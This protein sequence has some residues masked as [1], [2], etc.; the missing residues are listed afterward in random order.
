[1]RVAI[2]GAGPSGL[3]CAL[4]LQRLGHKP[5][6]F[7]RYHRVGHPVERVDTLLHLAWLPVRDQLSYLARK[8]GLHLHPLAPL[9]CIIMSSPG[10]RVTVR[11][12]RLGYLLVRGRSPLSIENQ[13]A[14]GLKSPVIFETVA[15]PQELARDFDWVVV[16][17]GDSKPTRQLNLWKEYSSAVIK[18][19]LV[20]GEFDPRTFHIFWDTRYAGHSFGYLAPLDRNRASIHLCIGGIEPEEIDDYWE[21]FLESEKLHYHIIETYEQEFH[22]GQPTRHRTGNI[23]LVGNSGGFVCSLL[24]MGLFPGLISGVLAARAIAG[25]GDYEKMVQPLTRR[26]EQLNELRFHLE[27]LD[28]RSLDRL[29]GILG[30]PVIKHL[31]Y[32]SGLNIIPII[33]NML[34]RL[35][36]STLRTRTAK[37]RH[38]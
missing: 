5:I 27:K 20:L 23:L 19:A 1:M 31:I 6:I 12:P 24:G 9:H 17:T 29:V 21:L 10:H 32:H 35:T 22:C 14:A 36:G 2:I 37:A 11:S 38:R 13:L 28:N 3:A 25:S 15:D 18:G 8:C 33:C 4:E 7:E 30:L 16:A 34:S 26:L